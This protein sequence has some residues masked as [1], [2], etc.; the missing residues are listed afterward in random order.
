MNYTNEEILAATTKLV[1]D[2]IRRPYGVLGNRDTSVTLTDIQDAA[3]GVFLLFPNAPFYALFLGTERVRDLVANE[4]ETL[5]S[6]INNIVDVGRNTTA[7]DTLTSLNNASVALTALS[8]AA[9][10]RALTSGATFEAITAVPAWQRFDDNIGRF[11]DDHAGNIKNGGSIVDTPAGARAALPALITSLKAEH[12]ELVRRVTLLVGGLDDFNSLQ[13]RATLQASIL[14]RAQEV[15]DA[16]IATLDALTPEARLGALRDVTIDLLAARAVVRSFGS[17][18]SPTLFA[19]INGVGKAFADATRPATAAAATADLFSPFIILPTESQLDFFLDGEVT[20]TSIVTIQGSFAARLDG[21]IA[22]P[23]GILASP[24]PDQN[25]T[26]VIRCTDEL[27]V[28]VGPLTPGAAVTIEAVVAEINADIAAVVPPPPIVAEAYFNPLKFTGSVIASTGPDTFTFL[29][30]SVDAAAIGVELADKV[31]VI[32]GDNAGNIYTVTAIS[33]PVPPSTPGFLLLT[34]ISGIHV[35]AT[36]DIVEIGP[37]SRLLRLRITDAGAAA[38]LATNKRIDLIA[39]DAVATAAFETLGYFG[40]T[41]IASRRTTADEVVNSIEIAPGAA[42]GLNTRLVASKE[43]IATLFSG[44]GH[45]VTTSSLK[46]ILFKL[47][48]I[49]TM[50]TVLGVTTF[51][52]SNTSGITTGDYVALREPPGANDVD[53]FGVITV[54]D[55][56]SF[57]VSSW[58]S[59]DVLFVDPPTDG[60]VLIDVGPNLVLPNDCILR[61]AENSINDGD[62]TVSYSGA[63]QPFSIPFELPLTRSIP[64]ITQG[65]QAVI[66]NVVLGQ[67]RVI[68]SSTDTTLATRVLVTDGDTG[69]GP[70]PLSAIARFVSAPPLNA[71]GT[72]TFF[73]IPENPKTLEVGDQLEFYELNYATVSQSFIIAALQLAD[74]IIEL[75]TGLATNEPSFTFTTT[76]QVPPFARIR[77]VKRDNFD[78][79]STAAMAWLDSEVNETQFFPNLDRLINPLLSGNPSIVQINNAKLA[80]Q[81]MVTSLNDLSVILDSY[82]VSEVTQV[83]SLIDSFLEKGSDRAVDL[84]LEGQFSTFFGLSV[85][86]QSYAGDVLAKIK[87]IQRLDLPVKKVRRADAGHEQILAQWE[88][89]DF[90]FDQSDISDFEEVDIPDDFDKPFPGQA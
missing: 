54:V 27:D 15:L 57:T 38:A 68:F 60:S 4:L 33:G 3:A 41:G 74:L 66:N 56:T 64:F 85:D 16:N 62:Y 36:N 20:Q 73:Q 39:D 49:A 61:I 78:V 26:F 17:L 88:E 22:E 8:G 67:E 51:N 58:N 11:L 46:Y 70:N 86:G 44:Q 75:K 43:L 34:V 25:D 5:N 12:A 65:G 76:G 45:S 50:T 13:L 59:D 77:K 71:V 6:L 2:A 82:N 24:D 89:P 19:P 14:Q 81:D 42:V 90:E 80:L 10:R 32:S 35:A 55:S 84:L 40:N 87:E 1:R 9:N 63:V 31:V 72:T 7:V 48:E 37:P 21:L 79:F 30:A 52:V 69:G 53:A 18:T 28:P 23:F 47:R 83:N 29:N